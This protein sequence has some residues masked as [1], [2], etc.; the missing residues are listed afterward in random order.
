MILLPHGFSAR[1]YQREIMRAYFEKQFRHLF[2]VIH[3]RAGKDLTCL[4]IMLMAAIQRVGTYLYL[5]PQTNQARRVMWKG[6]TADGRKFLDYIPQELVY[7]NNGTEMSV[8]LKNGSI[9][10][11]GGSNN[12]NAYMGTNPIFIVYSEY[13]L[14]NPLARNYLSPILRENKGSEIIQGTP[15]G[16]NHAYHLFNAAR[17]DEQWFTS[18]LTVEDTKRHDGTPVVSKDDIEHERRLGMSEELIRQE[19]YCD[20]S[21]GMQ[22]AYFTV[23]M[24]NAE[25][26]N[27][28]L[29]FEINN[30]N[31]VFTSWDLGVSDPTCITFFTP[32]NL[33]GFD[34]LYYHESTDKGVDYYARLI[35]ELQQKFNWTYRYHFAPHDIMQREWGSGA[36]SAMSL[37]Q[38]HGLHFLRV[39]NLTKDDQIQSLR[40]L[41]PKIRFHKENCRLLVDSLKEYRREWDEVNRVFKSKPLH[42]W[43]SHPVDSIMY[44]AIAYRENFIR[45]ENSKSIIYSLDAFDKTQSRLNQTSKNTF[46]REAL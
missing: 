40:A 34:C 24:D 39:P 37:A 12:F 11:F 41:L 7:K 29:N 31:A 46:G 19:W 8:E 22:G 35:K 17:N 38:E 42:N 1:D 21:V 32:N 10:Q 26:Q 23:E 18:L 43:C 9:I 3:R 36:R 13:P 27:R 45:P 25:L 33:G 6:I 30:N 4:Q 16:K 2:L 5:L 20:W 28:I 44:G 14:H 15:R